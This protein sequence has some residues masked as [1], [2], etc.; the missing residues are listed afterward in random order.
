MLEPTS[1]IAGLFWRYGIK[2]LTWIEKVIQRQPK[3]ARVMEKKQRKD[4][5]KG[6]PDGELFVN[7]HCGERVEQKEPRHGDGDGGRVIDVDRS[8]E[9]TLLAL[10]LKLA[11][12]AVFEHLERFC[13]ELSNA[14][15]RTAQTERRP[16]HSQKPRHDLRSGLARRRRPILV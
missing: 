8:D 12:R 10:E 5:R 6:H 7:R 4:D 14:A 3:A 11:V 9:V 2:R 16:Q 15:T 13:V 1:A